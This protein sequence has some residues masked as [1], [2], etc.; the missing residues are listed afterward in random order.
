M[1]FI[2]K[3]AEWRRVGIPDNVLNMYFAD[4]NMYRLLA[5]LTF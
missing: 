5:G 3:L 4:V 1:Y 2:K